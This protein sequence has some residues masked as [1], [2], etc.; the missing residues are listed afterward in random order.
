MSETKKEETVKEAPVKETQAKRTQPAAGRAETV[1]YIGPSI[2]NVVVTGTIYTNG[3]P[4]AVKKEMERQP[5]LKSLLVPISGLA[6][7]QK[8]LNIPGSAMATI[9]KKV[10]AE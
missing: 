4:E 2:K 6:E 10:K 3:L 5:A 1:V 9:Y 8:E 7:A